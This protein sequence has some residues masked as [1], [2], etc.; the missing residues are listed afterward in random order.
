MKKSILSSLVF[1]LIAS[2]AEAQSTPKQND[3]EIGAGINGAVHSGETDS[4]SIG[5]LI[6]YRQSGFFTDNT[7]M[8]GF[9]EAEANYNVLAKE[10]ENMTS[11][12]G[13]NA[14]AFVGYS[15]STAKIPTGLNFILVGAASG[16]FKGGIGNNPELRN[17]GS[18]NIGPQTGI[19]YSN[20]T[21]KAT[22]TFGAGYGLAACGINLPNGNTLT[23]ND[24]WVE[25]VNDTS[26]NRGEA[27]GLA[28]SGILN[29]SVAKKFN[30]R[31]FYM[32]I[33][34]N[35]RSFTE[36]NAA[37]TVENLSKY[38]KRN[39]G[40]ITLYWAVD[41]NFSLNARCDV[42]TAE[43]FKTVNGFKS[44]VQNLTQSIVSLGLVR[45][46]PGINR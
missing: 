21:F 19:M 34:P 12:L 25:K 36:K 13:F 14:A 45:T 8:V 17:F 40:A 6:K 7:R 46:F 15:L 43:K 29:V 31:L 18:F 42:M 30:L 28:Y 26:M 2:N 35:E 11:Y 4:R 32:T 10:A 20:N 44:E 33:E 27:G 37:G 41:K 39:A 1:V 22:A 23:F 24:P 3:L 38:S 16:G 9:T 5:T